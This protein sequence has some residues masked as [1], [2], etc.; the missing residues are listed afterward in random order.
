MKFLIGGVLLLGFGLGLTTGSVVSRTTMQ[1]AAIQRGIA[2]YNPT[3]GEFEFKQC[4][5]ILIPN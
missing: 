5:G 4:G 1:Q 3:D 2:Q